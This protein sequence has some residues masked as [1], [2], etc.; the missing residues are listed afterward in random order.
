M[1]F[2]WVSEKSATSA[3]LVVVVAINLA[4]LGTGLLFVRQVE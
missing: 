4:L 1:G 2:G 3:A